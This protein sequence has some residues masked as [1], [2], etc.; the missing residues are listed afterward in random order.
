MGNLKGTLKRKGKSDL[1]KY[2]YLVEYCN[3]G[4][5]QEKWRAEIPKYKWQ[6][7]FDVEK[8]AGKAVDLKLIEMNQKPINVLK[9]V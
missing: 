6:K 1:Y 5:C 4:K 7:V 2:V 3:Q 9:R 8:E